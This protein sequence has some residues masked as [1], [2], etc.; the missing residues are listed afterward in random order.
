MKNVFTSIFSRPIFKVISLLGL[1]LLIGFIYLGFIA[2][3]VP[4]KG[5]A[6]TPAGQFRVK[7]LPGSNV[8]ST[9]KQ[10]A[11]QGVQVSNLTM[12]IVARVLFQG[13]KLKAGVYDFAP[14]SSL[15]T[16]LFKMGR[17]DS[18]KL[19]VTLVEGWTFKQ[20][21]SAIDVQ[22]DLKKETKGLTAKQILAKLDAKEAHP[23]GLFFPD[24]YVYEPGDS[25]LVIYQKAYKA[26]QMKLN[27][28]WEARSSDSPVKSPY[29]LLKLASIVEKE[30]GHPDDRGLV[31]AVFNNRLKLGMKLQTDPTIIYGLGDSFDGNIR[32]KDLLKDGPYNT[33]TRYGLPPTPIAMP[34]KNALLA[35]AKPSNSKALYFVARGDGRS[36]FSESLVAHNEAVRKY[37]LTNT[38]A[39]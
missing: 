20:F 7:V 23:E 30:T 31:S 5:F 16:I 14:K 22:V 10:L 36:T 13:K 17:G 34:G 32:K 3:V 26:M 27:D 37:Q 29:D 1:G 19:G 4:D 21:K 18:I 12:Q 33:Y 9:A 2:P 8:A 15:A 11:S 38:Q 28:A 6:L 24:T 35:A 25:D 39:K